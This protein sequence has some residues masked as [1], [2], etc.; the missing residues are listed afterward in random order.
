MTVRSLLVVGPDS[1]LRDAY[2][3]AVQAFPNRHIEMLHIP[4]V[5]YYQFDLTG[6][7]NFSSHVWDICVA[8]NEFYI[9]DVRRSL[10]AMVEPMGYQF[11]SLISPQASIDPSAVVGNNVIIHAGC[12][13][14][15]GT[16]LG[17][18]CVLRPNV[19][20]GEDV[21]IGDYVTLEANVSV[22]ELSKIGSFTTICANS[23]LVRMSDVGDHCY[24]NLPR[25]Y[26]GTIPDN[27]FYS[28]SFEN[29][30]RVF[31]SKCE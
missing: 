8:V 19:V 22:R 14:G 29:P 26:R 9:N 18:H 1:T 17:H 20:L 6:L 31:A 28:P 30:V 12:F 15:A 3:L 7:A 21:T 27:T 11:T 13:V 23:S 4:S 2:S 10:Y 5:D 24:L 16:T 25:Q